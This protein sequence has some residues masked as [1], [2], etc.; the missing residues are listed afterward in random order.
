M[1][2]QFFDISSIDLSSANSTITITNPYSSGD[3]TFASIS[4]NTTKQEAL[5]VTGDA[6]FHGDLKI[7]GKSLSESLNNIERRLAILNPNTELES[8][9]EKLKELGDQYRKLENEILEKQHIYNI[10]RK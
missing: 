1:N 7:K 6:E 10:L 2:N 3:Y 9:W 8:E 5:S 4:T